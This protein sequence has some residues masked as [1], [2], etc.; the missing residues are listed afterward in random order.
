MYWSFSSLLLAV[1]LLPGGV[2]LYAQ[3]QTVVPRRGPTDLAQMTSVAGTIFTGTVTA[4]VP[5]HASDPDRVASVQVSFRVEQAVRGTSAGQTFTIREWAGLWTTGQRYRIG[6]R[7]MLFLYPAS[8]VG[9]TSPVGG[10][11]GHFA[12]D[13]SGQML[14]NPVQVQTIKTAPIRVGSDHHVNARGFTRMI[15][16]MAEEE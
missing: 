8:K 7:L 4:I 1:W 14:L 9:L 12:I 13:Q 2:P 5:V 15:Q 16:R 3:V 11:A 6:E 10:A